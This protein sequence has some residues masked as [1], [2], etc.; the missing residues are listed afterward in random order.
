MR[1]QLTV[2]PNRIEMQMKKIRLAT[3]IL[4]PLVCLSPV[5]VS[6]QKPADACCVI[7]ALN[8]STGVATAKVNSSGN[9]FEFKA[10]DGLRGTLA[11]TTRVRVGQAVYANFASQ[12]VSLDGRTVCC[13]ILSAREVGQNVV[14]T[15]SDE[16]ANLW[17]IQESLSAGRT[18]AAGGLING[19]IY[20]AA[21]S[22]NNGSGVE[23]YDPSRNKWTGKQPTPSVSRA[24]AA[25][26][27]L[28][29]LLYVA[30]GISPGVSVADVAAYDP[31][32]NTWST[33][34][35][36]ET[37]RSEA[38]S[39]VLDGVLYV[40]GGRGKG[41][42]ITDDVTTYDPATNVWHTKPRYGYPGSVQPM[43][44]AGAAAGVINGIL[45]VV[46]GYY[47]D[48]YGYDHFLAEV[49]AYDPKTDMWTSRPP[50]LTARIAPSV[51]VVKGM[52]YVVGGS[53]WDGKRLSSIEAYNPNTN[54]WTASYVSTM[55][56]H[57][58]PRAP[59]PTAR[60]HSTVVVANGILYVIG[61]DNADG[62]LPTVEAFH[63]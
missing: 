61:G 28:N 44:R 21:G 31:V 32:T 52:M 8:A 23:A 16:S 3:A 42:A 50:M 56:V 48:G 46:G 15:S 27:V 55:A 39:A 37:V 24:F 62:N 63:P 57:A 26:G 38:A 49:Q 7:V 13:T 43:A 34:A 1:V 51:G 5:I 18:G 58:I 60:R 4:V 45:Y 19:I 30:G 59:M 54:K 36:M 35:P 47:K 53:D 22:G 2:H 20:V 11:L 25:A 33:K 6:A 17:T 29:G 10:V 14:R 40:V 9:A 12:Q 41:G